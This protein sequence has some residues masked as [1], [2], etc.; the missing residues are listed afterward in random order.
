[1]A[2][3]GI[4]EPGGIIEPRPAS[5]RELMLVHSS[6]YIEAVVEASDWGTGLHAGSGLG[7]E[8]NPIFPGMH[9]I[10]ALVCGA[11]I[12]ALEEVLSGRR[13]R[14]FSIAGGLHHAHR[15]RA[16]GF[17]VYNDAAVAIAV[18]RAAKP[19]L[20]VLY[21]D[22][23]AHHGDGVQEAFDGTSKVMTISLHESGLYAFPGTGFP[24]EM[25]YDEGRGYAVNV[26]MPRF[27]TDECY[28]LAFDRVVTP[29]TRAFKPDVI[30]GQFGADAHH[31]DPLTDLGMTLPGYRDL[32]DRV[33]G[34]ADEM[35]D[36]R[37]VAL[38][39]GGYQILNVVPLA[40]TWVMARLL[41]VGLADEIP[42][43]WRERVISLLRK[44]APRSLGA[45]DLFELPA[46]EAAGALAQT[47][48]VVR[49]AR[50][51]LFPL[52]GLIP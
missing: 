37:L 20:R 49:E 39:G 7:T 17:C 44:D 31:T 8:D 35:C 1:M 47:E 14:S 22:I 18:A 15:S 3:Y 2:A 38:G 51:L 32:V 40:W 27:A 43:S 5:D 25:G 33:V 45:T 42:E 4:P 52:H 9:R 10:S 50:G 36:G 11:S 28:R 16:A 41:G 46:E 29:L 21:I 26:P 24:S 6:G 12:V 34:L 30:V 23:D 19:E 13:T 48:A